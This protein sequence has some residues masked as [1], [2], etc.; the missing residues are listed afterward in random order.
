MQIVGIV[1]EY[2]PFHNG[3]LEQIKIIKKRLKDACIIVILSGSITQRGEIALFDKWV[4]AKVAV[5][6]GVDL[7]LELPSVFAVRSAEHFA[8][9]AVM[10]LNN[11]KIVDYIAFS[12]ENPDEETLS[13]L[14]QLSTSRDVQEKI[15]YL[16]QKG[17]SYAS[18]MGI[19]LSEKANIDSNIIRSPNNILAIEY[20]KALEKTNSMIKP[21]ILPRIG[22]AH[23]SLELGEKIVSSSAIRHII[24]NSTIDFAERLHLIKKN[25][26]PQGLDV[27]RP[28]LAS[29]NLPKAENIFLPLIAKLNF[30]EDK[31]LKNIYMLEEGLVE[32]LRKY[33]LTSN[34][35]EELLYLTQSKRY[36]KSRLRRLFIYLILG[37]KKEYIVNFD[38]KGP[39][40][41]RILA[42]N[43]QG[44]NLLRK[45]KKE[46][47]FTLINHI[48]KNISRTNCF[49]ELSCLEKML[50]FD[51]FATDLQ[52]LSLPQKKNLARDFFI[53]PLYI[54]T[55]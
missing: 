4:R 28:I 13:L 32:R 11:L 27:L 7:V 10:L 52:S 55:K 35:L 12:A 34:N 54:K 33:S 48:A 41:G 50:T 14:A 39:L 53:S 46:T 22:R 30:T 49:K 24:K 45:I 23:N 51:I 16:I 44:R 40:Y 15:A 38:R 1:A 25:M 17:S 43:N 36:Q 37:I 29:E 2:N 26:P 9:G 47:S 18:A 31:D 3:H 19:V 20:L 21:L 42:F 8:L 5:L 6:L